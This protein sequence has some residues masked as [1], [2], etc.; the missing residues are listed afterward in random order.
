MCNDG[1]YTGA[2]NILCRMPALFGHQSDRLFLTLMRCLHSPRNDVNQWVTQVLQRQ[3]AC[4][5]NWSGP[6]C[7][8]LCCNP[9]PKTSSAC[10]QQCASSTNSWTVELPYSLY[11]AVLVWVVALRIGVH[12]SL[13]C[14][15]LLYFGQDRSQED[16]PGIP[17]QDSA[18]AGWPSKVDRWKGTS[19]TTKKAHDYRKGCCASPLYTSRQQCPS[20]SSWASGRVQL[21]S[22]PLLLTLDDLS[23]TSLT[24][25]VGLKLSA[26]VKP[27]PAV[28]SS[29]EVRVADCRNIFVWLTNC[30]ISPLHTELARHITLSLAC[31]SPFSCLMC[32][33]H[34]P[35]FA[36]RESTPWL[37]W[38]R[39]NHFLAWFAHLWYNL[40]R[41]RLADQSARY[42]LWTISLKWSLTQ[43]WSLLQDFF[44]LNGRRVFIRS[45]L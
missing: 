11:R 18:W 12:A 14:E 31:F 28:K 36:H 26:A 5:R 22:Q 45:E 43:G 41:V 42:L 32:F 19:T 25:M 39:L 6:L 27:P 24:E 3:T 20:G 4:L 13:S 17:L 38:D 9:L 21:P 35:E 10:R 40:N 1:S 15:G 29:A 34:W 37:Y 2:C 33:H 23:W 7:Q 44:C 30:C 16:G 8:N